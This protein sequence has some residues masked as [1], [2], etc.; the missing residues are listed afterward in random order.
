MG[1][2]VGVGAGAGA[3]IYLELEPKISKMGS[4]GNPGRNRNHC[5]RIQ[6]VEHLQGNHQENQWSSSG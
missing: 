5:D 3:G 6:L 1:V 4:S 2:R